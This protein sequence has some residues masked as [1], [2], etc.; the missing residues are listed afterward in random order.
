MSED[1]NKP[2]SDTAT[3]SDAVN[4][5]S[6]ETT[7]QSNTTNDG[8]MSIIAHLTELRK[9]LIRSLIAIGIGSCIAYYFIE[10]IMH[11]LT[12]PAGKLYYMQPA[13]AFFTYIKVAIFVGFLIALPV[14]LYQIWRF[15]LPALIGMER[16]L[17][18]VIVPVSLILF[19]AGI[20]F[21][22]FLVLPA[23]VKF[24]VGF[25][26]QEL[27][28]M[29]SIK[30]Y[31]D[32]VIAFLLPFGFIFELPLAIILLAKVG[33]VSSKF[34]AKQQRIVIFLTFVIGAVISP[35]PDI[36][37]QCMIAIPMIL[38]YEISYVIVRFGMKK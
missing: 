33:I 34:L 25:S 37:S 3:V 31:F 23:A 7:S 15:V 36:F 24:L 35:T 17:L 12:G 16:Y 20:A 22:F 10:D 11:L 21:S 27:Q 2:T 14:V 18:S 28:P 19:L 13:E 32:F 6:T 5:P 1:M 4:L 9:R 26:T 38:L 29:F 30:Q 8:S